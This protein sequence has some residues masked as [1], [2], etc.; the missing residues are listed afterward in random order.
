MDN[1]ASLGKCRSYN[2][3][4]LKRRLKDRLHPSLW[5]WAYPP[6]SPTITVV[7]MTTTELISI[8]AL[9]V[10]IAAAGFTAKYAFSTARGVRLTH[11]GYIVLQVP[12]RIGF[13]GPNDLDPSKLSVKNAGKGACLDVLVV[14]RA[15]DGLPARRQFYQQIPS[16]EDPPIETGGSILGRSFSA[17]VSWRTQDGRSRRRRCNLTVPK[18]ASRA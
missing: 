1:S 17:K 14:I 16:L 6:P 10:S 18:P 4:A 7:A 5:D 3:G 9:V 12:S 11:E 15:H 13:P 8:C 2:A